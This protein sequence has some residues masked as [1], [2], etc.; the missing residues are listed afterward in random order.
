M[1]ILPKG[2]VRIRHY[3]I[4]SSTANKAAAIVIKQQLPEAVKPIVTKP[5]TEPY[6]PKQ[7]SCCKKETM[8]TVMRFKGRGPPAQWEQMATALLDCI[9]DKNTGAQ[10]NEAA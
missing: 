4:L 2:L 8:E 10:K 9:T 1:H 3:G 7:C 6:N 5:A